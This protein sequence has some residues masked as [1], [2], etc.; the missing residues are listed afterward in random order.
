MQEFGAAER[1]RR[2][3]DCLGDL[4]GDFLGDTQI[5]TTAKHVDCARAFERAAQRGPIAAG[6][7]AQAGGQLRQSLLQVRVFAVTGNETQAGED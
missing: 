4:Q 3:S 2:Y 7:R 6:G 1:Q 5:G